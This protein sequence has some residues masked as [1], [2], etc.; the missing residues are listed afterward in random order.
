MGGADDARVDRDRLAP[1]DPLDHPLLQ[2][3][4]QLDL[5]RQRDVAD[6]VEEQRAAMGQLD[7]ALGRLDR[8]GEGALLVAE[9]LAFEQV[10]GDRRAVDRDEAR[11]R[12]RRLASCRPRASNSLPVPLA[13][14]S[15]TETSV[16]ATRSIVRATFEHLGRGGDHRAEHRSSSPA[17]SASRAVLGLDAVQLEGAADDQAE[18]VDVDR[19]LVEIVGA[20]A[21][22]PAARFRARRGPRRRSPWCRASAPGSSSSVA[23]PSLTPSGS[24]GRPRSSVTTAGSS[25]RSASIARVAVA[26]DEHLDNRHRPSAAGAAGPRRPRRSAASALRFGD[27]AH[28]RSVSASSLR[29]ARAAGRR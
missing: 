24:G 16:L 20:R 10:L 9:Q 13:P 17:R 28:F 5:Q 7:L 25:A 23:K 21:R 6:L 27:H 3:A 14:S 12:A 18:L 8:A 22:S 1:A 26:G 19:L 15:I 29:L 11:R 2:E 4:Q